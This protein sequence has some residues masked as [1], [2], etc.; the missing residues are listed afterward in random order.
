M[1]QPELPDWYVRTRRYDE[2]S[3]VVTSNIALEK[4][5]YAPLSDLTGPISDALLWRGHQRRQQSLAPTPL[6]PAHFQPGST[7]RGLLD[8]PFSYVQYDVTSDEDLSG[9]NLTTATIQLRNA[10]NTGC[11]EIRIDKRGASKP[12]YKLSQ[13]KLI[14]ELKDAGTQLLDEPATLDLLADIRRQTH[15]YQSGTPEPATIDEFCDSLIAASP[16]VREVQEGIYQTY[17]DE[18]STVIMK[19]G[20]TIVQT[21]RNPEE[22]DIAVRL[23]VRQALGVDDDSFA[24]TALKFATQQNGRG[25]QASVAAGITAI[26]RRDLNMETRDSY[27]A[28]MIQV[29]R[30]PDVFM[31]RILT[32]IGRIL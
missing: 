14:H 12:T 27:L 1:R 8:T 26:S 4:A 30:E 9:S 5:D 2:S 18:T 3:T 16:K 22:T 10:G 7:H 20:K 29:Y 28:K 11:A 6:F 25:V 15:R 23:D 13:A 17:N 19:V 31:D 24:A 21:Y 32:N